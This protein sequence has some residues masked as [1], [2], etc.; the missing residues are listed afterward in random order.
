M[1]KLL[2]IM[3]AVA[4]VLTTVIIPVSVSA[5]A[6]SF[7]GD[8]VKGDTLLA[9]FDASNENDVNQLISSTGEVQKATFAG[10][11]Y[12]Y[13]S[14]GSDN[15]AFLQ[16]PQILP[17]LSDT[18]SVFVKLRLHAA[19]DNTNGKTVYVY[20]QNSGSARAGLSTV[21]EALTNKVDNDSTSAPGMDIILEM[22]A[23]G[24]DVYTKADGSD[25][26]S[27]DYT[28]KAYQSN[29]GNDKLCLW[30]GV[31]VS[32]VKVYKKNPGAATGA[33]ADCSDGDYIVSKFDA[34]NANDR[35]MLTVDNGSVQTTTFGDGTY[36]HAESGNWLRV[37]QISPAIPDTGSVYVK[38]Q[39]HAIDDNE[40]GKVLYQYTQSSGGRRA[41]RT[42][43][44]TEIGNNR[45]LTSSAAGVEVIF[46]F[47][48]DGHTNYV[49]TAGDDGI[50]TLLEETK[51]YSNNTSL[52]ILNLQYGLG[53]SKAVVYKKVDAA[54]SAFNAAS[55]NNDAAA[56]A[57]ALSTYATNYGIDLTK[58]DN[59]TND[60]AVYARL[61]N[62]NFATAAEV[63]AVFDAAVT[64]Q[65]G[66]EFDGDYV[67]GYKVYGSFDASNAD[68]LERAFV[69]DATDGTTGSV[70]T[71][72]Y[73]GDTYAYANGGDGYIQLP[74]CPGF[75]EGE[76]LYIKFRTHAITAEVA[77]KHDKYTYMY[78][79]NG[80]RITGILSE[81]EVYSGKGL[82]ATV[83]GTGIDNIY[84]ISETGAYTHY[85]RPVGS[86]D[87]VIVK[88][89]NTEYH[90]NIKTFKV[91]SG[92]GI[93][94]VKVQ[95]K[96][97]AEA[98]KA[99]TLTKT[100]D[101][102]FK[103]ESNEVAEGAA[104]KVYVGAYNAD[105]VLLSVGI[106]D[107]NA[108]GT[109]VNMTAPTSGT[110]TYFKAFIWNQN[111]TPL[112]NNPASC[113]ND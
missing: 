95:T 98:P 111:L 34:S 74:I 68:D 39:L 77:N 36:A 41:S 13:T 75:V 4:M 59:V 113:D 28:L 106:A 69:A 86:S 30:Y 61:F 110:V 109:T 49:R 60:N 22:K 64:A 96:E 6:A 8:F 89:G 88:T 5:D 93:S 57:T 24:F 40:T 83:D 102:S 108:E 37:P 25:V 32:S 19:Y 20:T 43:N 44:N 50:W 85:A 76:T 94:S 105:D 104:G 65:I 107:F 45:L 21:D 42:L 18:E 2:S 72:T 27:K 87:W 73:G 81:A 103:V 31:A 70:A 97:A 67:E 16:I 7:N 56:M 92:L 80:H 71:V 48:A 47:T 54:T 90:T 63:A 12:V 9:T 14:R 29:S 11:T 112:I 62:K 15:N 55:K 99:T 53:I 82:N 84:A 17:T 101:W 66:A 58:L 23:G 1:K 3:L 51:T 52:Q 79:A 26:W 33:A 35:A 91:C 46:E 78:F 38:Y 10:E 100:A